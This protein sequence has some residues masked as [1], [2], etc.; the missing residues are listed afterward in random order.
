M[1]SV[2]RFPVAQFPGPPNSGCL[3]DRRS[4]LT[5]AKQNRGSGGG[6]GALS[7]LPPGSAR[8]VIRY[9]EIS[10][11]RA[12]ST[13]FLSLL[14]LVTLMWGGCISCPQFFMAPKTEKSCCDETGKCKRQKESPVQKECQRMPLEPPSIGG[15]HHAVAIAT[16]P[17]AVLEVLPLPVI[18][19]DRT[20]RELLPLEHSPPDLQVLNVT[21]LI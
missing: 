10:V 21:F 9:P 3:C 1:A 15:S 17:R 12:V 2:D 8:S 5:I 16:L 13:S 6:P 20:Q 19:S 7:Y 11:L 14:L 4:G 18:V